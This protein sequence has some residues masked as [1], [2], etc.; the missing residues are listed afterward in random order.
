MFHVKHFGP[1]AAENLT[2]AKTALRSDFVRSRD[3]LVQSESGGGGASIA[4]RFARGSLRC[5]VHANMFDREHTG[6]RS[7]I[8]MTPKPLPQPPCNDRL[9]GK[10][11]AGMP[12]RSLQPHPSRLTKFKAEKV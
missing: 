1:I 4:Q 8:P 5:K 11:G 9:S 7:P 10:D 6:V 2:R 12:G 3:F